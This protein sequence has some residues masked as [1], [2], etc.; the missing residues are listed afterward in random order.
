MDLKES[1]DPSSM[2][3]R[4]VT[5]HGT[6][7]GVSFLISRVKTIMS[8]MVTERTTAKLG[9]TSA[10]ASI[11]FMIACGRCSRA[12]E[13]ARELAI[14]AGAVTRV[15]DRLETRRLLVRVRSTEDR[16]VARLSLTSEGQAIAHEMPNLFR[17]VND[18]LL[19]SLSPT[20][21]GFLASMLK[22]IVQNGGK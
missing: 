15:I 13:L 17:S 6:S 4:D 7:D 3:P 22:R 12:A 21:V 9:L 10:Q 19:A 11:L 8:N 1:C 20:E 16:R 14:D 2:P 5:A 18:Q